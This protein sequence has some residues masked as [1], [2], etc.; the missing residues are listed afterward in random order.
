MVDQMVDYHKIQ[1]QE[2][3]GNF[4]CLKMISKLAPQKFCQK[5]L[6]FGVWKPNK[7]MKLGLKFFFT[8]PS[9]YELNSVFSPS[10][11]HLQIAIGF[12]G[13]VLKRSAEKA[14]RN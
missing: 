10:L 3:L 5:N 8:C 14:L 11:E 13:K 4:F 7:D 2:I 9:T 12:E 6:D 1:K